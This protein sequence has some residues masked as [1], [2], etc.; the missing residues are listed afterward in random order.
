MEIKENTRIYYGGDMAN[1]PDF[2]TV[3]KVYTDKWGT[4]ADI[5]LD[6]GREIEALP[7]HMFSDVYLGHG[8]TR[9]VTIEAYNAYRQN[10]ANQYGFKYTNAI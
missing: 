6:D 5:I 3:K 9:Y 4:F 2:G 1:N 7:V 8:G 10:I